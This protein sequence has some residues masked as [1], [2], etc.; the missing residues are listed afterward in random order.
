MLFLDRTD[1]KRCR[2]LKPLNAIMPYIMRGR[3]ESAV[4]FSKDLDVENAVK[5]VHRKNAE[6]GEQRYSLFGLILAAGL[7]TFVEKPELNRFVH[8]RGIYERNHF[9]F[10]F[11]V[12]KRLTEEA[13]EA[14]AKV[15]FEPGDTIDQVMER[16]NA[17]VELA[18]GEMPTPADGEVDFVGRIPFGRAIST[19]IFR[20]LDRW[21][22][23][24]ASMVR[25]DPLFASA[26]FANLGS[27]G[28]DAPFHHAYE[29][30][31]ASLFVVLGRMFQ[32]DVRKSDG[33]AARRHFINVKVTVDERISE[34]IYFAHA[35]SLF[36]RLILHPELLE[37]P[38]GGLA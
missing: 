18:K 15:F 26:Y 21:N 6:S 29:W 1:G 17:A 33:S 7:R 35:A 8:R 28:L 24:P 2:G 30:G 5:Y 37:A 10:S 38:P 11:I 4:Y 12:K 16:F 22:I 23:A 34:G 31:T 25:A 13:P 3:N 27:L 14:N 9:A 32:E 19:A 20:F 36:Q